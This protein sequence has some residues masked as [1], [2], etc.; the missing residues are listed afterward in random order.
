MFSS[1]SNI[2]P[3]P[4]SYGY[5][6]SKSLLKESLKFLNLNKTNEYKAII[7]GPVTTNISRKKFNIPINNLVWFVNAKHYEQSNRKSYDDIMLAF[8]DFLEIYP[9]SFLYLDK[10][11]N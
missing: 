2:I 9:N 5:Y 7:L 8:K 6:A 10:I 11:F 4:A 1:T 3:N